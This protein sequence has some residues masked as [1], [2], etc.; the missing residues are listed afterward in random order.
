MYTPLTNTSEGKGTA[1]MLQGLSS[2]T[3]VA[4]TTEQFTDVDDLAQGTIAGPAVVVVS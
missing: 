3:F 1:K 2:I 4:I